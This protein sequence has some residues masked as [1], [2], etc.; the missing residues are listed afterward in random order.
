MVEKS[1]KVS[2]EVWDVAKKFAVSHN[3]TLQNFVESAIKEKI[4]RE[5]SKPEPPQQQPQAKTHVEQQ[6]AET[7]PQPL[8]DED[9]YAEL[10]KALNQ[11]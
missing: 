2:L 11:K 8:E 10:L 9:Q 5:Q 1:L 7:K 6:K 4:S 3:D